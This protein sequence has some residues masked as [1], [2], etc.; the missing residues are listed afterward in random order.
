MDSQDIKPKVEIDRSR[1]ESETSI[2]PKSSHNAAYKNL[3]T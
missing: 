2:K 1:N 3:S